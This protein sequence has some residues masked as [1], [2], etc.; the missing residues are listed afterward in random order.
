[1]HVDRQTD[2][3]VTKVIGAVR[4]NATWPER[5]LKLCSCQSAS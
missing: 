5:E 3:H 2:R 4:Y 1:M